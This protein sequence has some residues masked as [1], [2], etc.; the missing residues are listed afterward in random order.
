MLYPHVG[1]GSVHEPVLVHHLS[2]GVGGGTMTAYCGS[3]LWMAP[4]IFRGAQNY[5]SAVD[6]FSYGLVLWEMA[7]RLPPWAGSIN[8]QSTEVSVCGGISIVYRC[9]CGVVGLTYSGG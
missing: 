8:F 1:R 9:P 7:T 5:G 3:L 6:V 4:E 2:V